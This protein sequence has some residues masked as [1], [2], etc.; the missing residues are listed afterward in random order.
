[1]RKHRFETSLAAIDRLHEAVDRTRST[2]TTV[3]VLK[4]DLERL[5]RDH[6]ELAKIVEEEL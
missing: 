6:C 1:M 5:L 4:D 3:K 2:S